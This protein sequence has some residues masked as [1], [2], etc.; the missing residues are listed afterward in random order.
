MF[1]IVSSKEIIN[2][3]TI[4]NSIHVKY[5]YDLQYMDNEQFII[6]IN[7][8]YF[9]IEEAI[10]KNIFI[11]CFSNNTMNYKGKIISIKV[12]DLNLISKTINCIIDNSIGSPLIGMDYIDII[13]MMKRY[14]DAKVYFSNGNTIKEAISKLL[15]VISKGYCVFVKGNNTLTLKELEEGIEVLNSRDILYGGIIDNTILD[16]EVMLIELN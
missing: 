6:L 9:L 4:K 16:R 8:S 11:I 2:Q 14:N 10:N 12:N 5:H 1:H 3:L 7:P 15:S 13:N